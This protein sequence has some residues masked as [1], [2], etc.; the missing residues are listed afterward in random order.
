M[1]RIRLSYILAGRKHWDRIIIRFRHSKYQVIFL[2]R[3]EK[4]YVIPGG[5]RELIGA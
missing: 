2:K 5:G 1:E 4:G 3:G